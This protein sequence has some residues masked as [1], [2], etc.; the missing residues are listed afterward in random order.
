M[1]IFFH[2]TLTGIDCQQPSWFGIS[3]N[4]FWFEQDWRN[5]SYVEMLSWACGTTSQAFKLNTFFKNA[6]DFM[7]LHSFTNL[8]NITYVFDKLLLCARL[9]PLLQEW[10]VKFPCSGHYNVLLSLLH[11]LFLCSP[12]SQYCFFPL[13]L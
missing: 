6:F 2:C 10:M 4:G 8:T 3:L 1:N 13:P 9:W 5:Y 12:W 7:H 11:Q